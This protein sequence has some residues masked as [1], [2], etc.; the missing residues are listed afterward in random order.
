MLSETL[1]YYKLIRNEDKK[2]SYFRKINF[3]ATYKFFFFSADDSLPPIE[4]PQSGFVSI[5]QDNITGKMFLIKAPFNMVMYS[6]R[7]HK[8]KFFYIDRDDFMK[9]VSYNKSKL[10]Q[11]PHV[12]KNFLKETHLLII[13]DLLKCGEVIEK[14]LTK[15]F[16]D[17]DF[18][19]SK[20]FYCKAEFASFFIS[21]DDFKKFLPEIEVL[22]DEFELNGD[23]KD[24]NVSFEDLKEKHSNIFAE[25]E[26]YFP[27]SEY[28]IT[29]KFI[30]FNYYIYQLLFFL[31]N[32]LRLLNKYNEYHFAEVIIGNRL[33]ILKKIFKQKSNLRFHFLFNQDYKNEYQFFNDEEF[34]VRNGVYSLIN[35]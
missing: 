16:E 6:I 18:T 14:V 1:G 15:V 9:F 22:M 29:E 11:P 10:L 27:Q 12:V 21:R 32:F 34:E 35:L 4:V 8:D 33:L 3:M 26:K 17:L 5:W 20:P 28:L 13:K 23:I 24:E 19:T 7:K 31:K 30:I 2:D 25:L